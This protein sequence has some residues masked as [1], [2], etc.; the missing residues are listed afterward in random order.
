M[1]VRKNNILRTGNKTARLAFAPLRSSFLASR[2]LSGLRKKKLS[3][4][5]IFIL[6][7]LALAPPPAGI[8]GINIKTIEG[9]QKQLSEY[10]NKKMLIITLPLVRSNSADSFLISVDSLASVNL[11]T[12]KIITVPSVEDGYTSSQ[13]QALKNW[14]RQFLDSSVV[15]TTGIYTRKTSGSQ[16]HKLFKWLTHQSRNGYF[17][18]DVDGPSMKFLL[19]AN[20]DL[21]G[22]LKKRSRLGGTAM[23]RMLQTQ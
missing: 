23:Q 9:P 18:E 8:Y 21:M 15:I 14:Y 3:I 22:V 20:G 10:Q 16:Q 12:L 19:R 2:L 5:C 17:N 7:M 4:L 11:A 6:A 13:K 1:R